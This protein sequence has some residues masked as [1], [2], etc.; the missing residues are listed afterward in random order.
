MAGILL[1]ALVVMALPVGLIIAGALYLV[2][3]AL[4]S[5]PGAQ[6]ADASELRRYVHT[7]A[8]TLSTLGVSREAR[9]RHVD[10]L[11]GNLADAVAADGVRSALAGLGPAGALAT[12]YADYRPRPAWLV[13]LGASVLTLAVTWLVHLQLAQSYADG[14]T[15]AAGLTGSNI[16]G[17]VARLN[18]WGLHTEAVIGVDSQVTATATSPLLIVLPVVAFFVA[19]RSWRT[20]ALRSGATVK[21]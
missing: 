4:Y 8:R 19:S 16:S 11:K 21:A 7:F 20:I 17:N 18:G 10:E 6:G 9:R 14:W 5:V 13:G 15:D 1:V 3:R 2:R 12:G